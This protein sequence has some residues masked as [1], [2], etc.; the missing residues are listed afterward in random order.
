MYLFK[1]AVVLTLYGPKLTPS[2]WLHPMRNGTLT[3]SPCSICVTAGCVIRSPS[4]TTPYT[5]ALVAVEF[6]TALRVS[7]GT[8]LKQSRRLVELV[9]PTPAEMLAMTGAQLCGVG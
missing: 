5:A 7:V 9:Q 6:N 2:S 1:S 8:D 3:K 4:T